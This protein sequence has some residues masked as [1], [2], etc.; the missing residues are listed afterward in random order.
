MYINDLVIEITRKCNLKC[1]HCLRGPAQN[2]DFIDL[3]KTINKFI[4]INQIES[5]GGL[6]IS[7]GEPLLN[8]K[9]IIDLLKIF[10]NRKI[11]ING[12]CLVTN[13]TMFDPD[14][15]K[16]ISKIYQICDKESFN[17]YIS[18]GEYHNSKI[19]SRWDLINHYDRNDP[20]MY[21][22]IAEGRGEKLN[23]FGRKVKECEW[24]FDEGNLTSG[25]VYI[26]V[27]GEIV[28]SCDYSYVTQKKKKIGHCCDR[29]LIDF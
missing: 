1:K 12:F 7:G 29:K 21:Y 26:N 8:S 4:V 14:I 28:K 16:P 5:I 3:I 27:F 25:E 23:R 19:D 18:H 9:G 24:E 6:S 13:G 11:D 15:L 2:I 20:N 17:I 10:I 22:V